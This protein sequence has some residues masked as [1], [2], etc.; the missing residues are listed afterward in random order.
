MI[1]TDKDGTAFEIHPE[2]I[3][4]II[5]Q[6]KQTEIVCDNG[7][8]IRTLDTFKEIA[9]QIR[10]ELTGL[11]CR[12]SHLQ[13]EVKMIRTS[14]DRAKFVCQH[15]QPMCKVIDPNIDTVTYY[16]SISRDE[17]VIVKWKNGYTKSVCVSMDSKKAIVTD[18][19]K[20]I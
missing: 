8:R 3:D 10:A 5:P 16:V 9:M 4:K 15:L 18:V 11:N 20:I 2:N 14:E 17:Y 13:G 12:E 1:L 7:S 19:F 6:G